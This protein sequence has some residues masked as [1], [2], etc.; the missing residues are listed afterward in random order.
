[1][2]L[3]FDLKVGDAL[4]IDGGRILLTLREKSGKTARVSVDA[5]K[6]IAVEKVKGMTPAFVPARAGIFT[7]PK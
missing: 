2:A 1:M 7:T 6:S 3:S 4:R 5:D